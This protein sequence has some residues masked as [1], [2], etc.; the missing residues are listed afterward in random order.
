MR[1]EEFSRKILAPSSDSSLR[2]SKWFYERA[3]GQYANQQ[4]NLTPAQK[5]KFLLEHPRSQMLTKTDLAKYFLSFEE[6]PQIVSLGAQK[7]FAGST[8]NNKLP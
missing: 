4:A 8:K 1:I 7:A 5:K 3:R 6:L 2:G